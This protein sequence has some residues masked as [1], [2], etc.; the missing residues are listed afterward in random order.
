M[1]RGPSRAKCSSASQALCPREGESLKSS[2]GS[3]LPFQSPH[4]SSPSREPTRCGSASASSPQIPW[5][6]LV[7]GPAA[8]SGRPLAKAPGSCSSNS[9]AP[10]V[11]GA[12]RR[13]VPSAQ[14][15][16]PAVPGADSAQ[17]HWAMLP[18]GESR[19][20][21]G[22]PQPAVVRSAAPP[23]RRQRLRLPGAQ[24]ALKRRAALW[25]GARLANRRAAC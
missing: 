18:S 7:P 10:R 14:Q 5:P 8:R 21:R 23:P 19:R 12:Q 13:A 24:P 16:Y 17:R 20:A 2:F 9:C 3:C 15:T 1:P 11:P 4:G 6:S 22:A 25:G